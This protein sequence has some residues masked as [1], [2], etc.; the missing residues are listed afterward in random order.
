MAAVSEISKVTSLPEPVKPVKRTAPDSEEKATPTKK[1]RVH[2][3]VGRILDSVASWFLQKIMDGVEVAGKQS[4]TILSEE[5][6]KAA[7][8]SAKKVDEQDDDEILF[9]GKRP[10]SCQGDEDS[11]DN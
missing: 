8:V 6:F 2:G 4:Q 1:A 11:A 7:A 3:P 10:S 9:S 5:A